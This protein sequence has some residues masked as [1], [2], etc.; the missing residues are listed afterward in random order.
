VIGRAVAGGIRA[1]VP[2]SHRVGHAGSH[3]VRDRGVQRRAVPGPQAH[4]GH[5]DGGMLRGIGDPVHALDDPGELAGAVVAEGTHGPQP[6]AGGPSYHAEAV[7]E[8]GGRACHVRAVTVAVGPFGRVTAG[9]VLAAHHVEV[10]M[11]RLDA[12]VDDG[13]I[14]VDPL[15]RRVVRVI[16]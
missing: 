16:D 3:G 2:R 13:D 14:H 11:V 7:V 4:I 9:E 15:A 12:G 1:V 10:R 8:G 6:G 5:L